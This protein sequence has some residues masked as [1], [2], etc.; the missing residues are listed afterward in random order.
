MFLLLK[1]SIS[2][3]ELVKASRMLKHFCVQIHSLYGKRYYTYNIHSLVHL[4]YIIRQ[5]GP[6]WV[7][8]AFWYEDYSGNYKN[9]FH[10]TQN[11]ILQIVTYEVALQ[12]ISEICRAPVPGTVAYKLHN[13]M[14]KKYHQSLKD[15]GESILCGVNTVGLLQ[16][17]ALTAE[18]ELIITMRLSAIK[19]SYSFD[20]I[21]FKQVVIHSSSYKHV[22][23][24]NV[25]TVI[26]KSRFGISNGYVQ[27]YVKV[28]F[29]CSRLDH[30][31]ESC[32]CK[33]YHLLS[34]LQTPSILPNNVTID[35][36]TGTTLDNFVPVT[37]K[38]TLDICFV[39]H[40]LDI[41][42]KNI[43]D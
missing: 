21:Y 7:H 14:T 19:V 24:R 9:L 37:Q 17:D 27:K 23:K 36:Y 4:A 3:E 10:G 6:L 18:E 15:L 1:D 28:L 29:A 30:C 42:C 32:I 20:K 33:K 13:Q 38:S 39:A 31:C 8:S 35:N 43:F 2:Y 34:I 12:N 41:S 22:L 40:I 25:F 11:V 26:C 16:K 5:L